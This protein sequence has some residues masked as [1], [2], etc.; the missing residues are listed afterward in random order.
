M[1]SVGFSKAVQHVMRWIDRLCER[2][3]GVDIQLPVCTCIGDSGNTESEDRWGRE[4]VESWP[5]AG[6]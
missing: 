1:C 5:R 4:S 2:G 3:K 6:I